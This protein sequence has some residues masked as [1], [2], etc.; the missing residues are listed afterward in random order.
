MKRSK[1]APSIYNGCAA[2]APDD[3]DTAI[4][5]RRV[6]KRRWTKEDRIARMNDQQMSAMIKRQHVSLKKKIRKIERRMER[7]LDE[8]QQRKQQKEQTSSCKKRKKKRIENE[9][10]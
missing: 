9:V 6:K 2:S 10:G 1:G 7:D 5:P 4:T 3:D 8:K